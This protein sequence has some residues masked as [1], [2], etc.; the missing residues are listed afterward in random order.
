MFQSDNAPLSVPAGLADLIVADARLATIATGFH[1][2]E[3]P[4]W[5]PRKQ[6]LLFSD[7]P[8]DVRR[9]WR[10][11]DGVTEILRPANKCNGMTLDS[12]GNLYV[13]EHSTSQLVREAPDGT[14]TVL[15][16]NWQG[17]ELNSP[18]DVVVRAD[19]NVYFSD[20]SYGR[21]P[22]FG[23]ERDCVLP[24]RGLYRVDPTGQLHLEVSDW[25]QVNGLC[26]S[27]DETLL[28][29]N[30]SERAHIRR[31]EVNADGSLGAENVFA[32]DIGTGEFAGG[33]V[34]GMKCDELGNIWVTGPHGI[35][36]FSPDGVHLGILPL[37]E[38]AGN[39]TWGGPS[40]TDLF[41]C[42]STSVYMVKTT[43]R[44]HR[45]GYMTG[46]EAAA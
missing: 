39:L 34:D 12:F 6:E 19:G 38:H 25:Q 29:V 36:V 11:G 43:V 32:E 16:S 23:L 3:G 46:W 24:H 15:A 44:G 20:P 37:P 31:F 41:L 2:T 13:C 8:G 30:D 9:R 1:F 28:Y 17:A 42:C 14:R 27:P 35:W 22:V 33:I 18:N 5:D 40:W 21:M 7:M 10:P 26:F 4:I 45:E